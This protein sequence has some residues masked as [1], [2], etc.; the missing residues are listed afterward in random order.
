MDQNICEFN[1]LKIMFFKDLKSSAQAGTT[2]VQKEILYF[3]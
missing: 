2:G 3:W 1:D